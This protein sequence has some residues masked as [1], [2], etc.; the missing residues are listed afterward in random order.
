MMLSFSNLRCVAKSEIILDW[1]A[2]EVKVLCIFIVDCPANLALDR[3]GG[4]VRI[5]EESALIV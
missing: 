5:D 4:I 3:C 1:A 2:E